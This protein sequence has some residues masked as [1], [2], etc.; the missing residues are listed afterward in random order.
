MAMLKLKIKE[1]KLYPFLKMGHRALIFGYGSPLHG[2]NGMEDG[3]TYR[4][5]NGVAIK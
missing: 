2:L 5:G 4:M 3:S 1:R